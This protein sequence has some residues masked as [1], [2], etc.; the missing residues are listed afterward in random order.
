MPVFLFSPAG[1]NLFQKLFN[2]KAKQTEE[3]PPEMK[4]LIAGLG[5]PGPEY[6]FNRHNIGFMALDRMVAKKEELT[7]S[8]DRYGSTC[9]IRHRGKQLILLK[10]MTYMNLSGKAVRYHLQQNKIDVSR[11]LVITDDIAL[12]FGK[13]RLKAQGS[14]G[15]H[16]GLTNIEELLGTRNYARLRFGVGSDFHRGGQADYVL[17]DFPEEE[18]EQ[19]PDLLDT[20]GKIIRSFAVDGV[21]RTMS[22]FNQK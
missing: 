2:F 13:L 20:C 3:I 6:A 22:N 15:G 12:P 11:L 9:T 17:S 4:F 1:M 7:F 14:A 10:P 19:I 21:S 8:S 16:N 5:N 18:M